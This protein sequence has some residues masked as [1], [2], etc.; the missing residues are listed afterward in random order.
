MAVPDYKCS[1][2]V[3]I[4]LSVFEKM[5]GTD[6]T[7]WPLDVLD[8]L[9]VSLPCNDQEYELRWPPWPQQFLFLNPWQVSYQMKGNTSSSWKVV[10]KF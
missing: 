9:E 4:A 8:Q 10:K 1:K 3:K 7:I 2:I 5:K 6:S